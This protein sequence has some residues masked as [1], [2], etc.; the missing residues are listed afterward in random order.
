MQLKNNSAILAVYNV[1]LYVKYIY[2]KYATCNCYPNVH[3]DAKIYVENMQHSLDIIYI[4]S[5]ETSV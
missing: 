2:R 3:L 5:V 1:H 4:Y